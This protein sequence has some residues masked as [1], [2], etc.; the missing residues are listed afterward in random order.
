M[1]KVKIGC[2]IVLVKRCEGNEALARGILSPYEAE[3]YGKRVNKAEFLAGHF[4][5]K[6]AF[7]K[8]EGTGLAKARLSEIEIRYRKGGQPYLL[9]GGKEY[10]CSISH[11]GGYAFAVVLYEEPR[12]NIAA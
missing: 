12:K 1:N 7:L 11:D 8:A 3:E 9:F 4:A 2:D 5:A 10:E 6:E